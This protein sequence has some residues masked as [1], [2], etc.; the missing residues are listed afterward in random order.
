MPQTI[1]GLFGQSSRTL[2][3]PDSD[4]EVMPGVAWGRFDH[5]LTPAFWATQVWFCSETSRPGAHRLGRTLQ[6]E[7]AACVLGGHGVPA[8][9]GLASYER[10][11]SL[12]LIRS[13]ATEL[14]L[15]DALS[16]PMEIAG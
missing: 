15:R 5:L 6:E 2:D 9:V 12:G 4:A 10:L 1:Y 7:V 11:R 13:S 3:L 8:E 14:E 16:Q